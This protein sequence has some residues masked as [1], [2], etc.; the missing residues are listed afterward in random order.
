MSQ[1]TSESRKCQPAW[2]SAGLSGTPTGVAADEVTML[3]KH[4]PPTP[5]FLKK[6]F[7]GED[8]R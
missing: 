8:V 4:L 5:Q 7:V 3:V 2:E 6:N 1:A